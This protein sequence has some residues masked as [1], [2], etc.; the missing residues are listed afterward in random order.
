MSILILLLI[1]SGVMVYLSQNNL[2]LVSL[3]LGPYVFSNIPLFY[4][5]IGSLLVGLGLAYLLYLVNS[6]FT[7]FSLRRKDKKI[8]QAKNEI[9]D[10]T[11][12]IHKLELENEKLKH[13]SRSTEP[14][15]PNAL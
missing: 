2:M 10:L 1:V 5:I 7:A 15:D 8:K 14:N 9:A 12:Q 13:T 4:V 6:I 11:K 3:Y